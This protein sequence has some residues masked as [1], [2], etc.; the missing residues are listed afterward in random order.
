IAGRIL[1]KCLAEGGTQDACQARAN[2]FA[3]NCKKLCDQPKPP[4]PT[5]SD[6]CTAVAQN[7][8]DVCIKA[9]ESEADCKAQSDL[10]LA[11]C[12]AQCDN[13]SGQQGGKVQSDRLMTGC[14]AAGVA[15]DECQKRVAAFLERCNQRC[16]P[17]TCPEVCGNQARGVHDECITAG[18]TEE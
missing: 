2:T 14:L 7:A 10:L 13:P 18:G 15:A 8:H 4:P 11:D 12:N 5:C 3:A 1:N 17:L 16:H 6:R 9:G